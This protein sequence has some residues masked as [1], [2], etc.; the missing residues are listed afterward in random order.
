MEFE[1]S[2]NY[3][4][5]FDKLIYQKNRSVLDVAYKLR[6]ELDINIQKSSENFINYIMYLIVL[7]IFNEKNEYN[8]KY[9]KEEKEFINDFLNNKLD[10]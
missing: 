2:L 9:L 3:F 7:N 4:N 5:N 1:Y 6:Q 8:K 10:I